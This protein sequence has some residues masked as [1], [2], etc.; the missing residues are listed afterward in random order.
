MGDLTPAR[1]IIDPAD[2]PRTK[3]EPM[4]GGKFCKHCGWRKERHVADWC[5]PDPESDDDED[6]D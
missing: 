3:W 5:A 4:K 1:E 6:W 2:V